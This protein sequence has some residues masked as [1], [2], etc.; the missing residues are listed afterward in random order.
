MNLN[1]TAEQLKAVKDGATIRVAVPELGMECVVVRADLY[2]RLVDDS[3]GE[4]EVAMLIESSMREYDQD[5]PTLA[6]LSP[7]SDEALHQ[8]QRQRTGKPLS[9]VLADLPPND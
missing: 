2:S 6:K 5:D 9:D 8:R 4:T 3:I 7:F 1:L